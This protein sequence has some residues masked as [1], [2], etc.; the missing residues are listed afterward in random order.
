[1]TGAASWSLLSFGVWGG[2]GGCVGV[3]SDRFQPL[4]PYT[5]PLNHAPPHPS[6]SIPHTSFS[7]HPPITCQPK[8]VT[9]AGSLERNGLKREAG[10]LSVSLR[11]SHMRV[12]V[13]VEVKYSLC[14]VCEAVCQKGRGGERGSR[15]TAS[16]LSAVLCSHLLSPSLS[17]ICPSFSAFPLSLFSPHVFPLFTPSF[18]PL[19]SPSCSVSHPLLSGSRWQHGAAA[20]AAATEHKPE[21]EQEMGR[22]EGGCGKRRRRRRKGEGGGG[23]A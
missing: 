23:Q 1:M 19:F 17:F 6:P 7:L 11:R 5:L 18:S 12:R 15:W 21:C 2:V 4:I 16:L 14:G 3:D 22:G 20:A 13:C 10:L 8:G 9:Q